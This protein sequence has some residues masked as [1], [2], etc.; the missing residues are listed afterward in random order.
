MT[1]SQVQR[2]DFRQFLLSLFA[3]LA[4]DQNFRCCFK[5]NHRELH[6][7]FW[8]LKQDDPGKDFVEDLLFDR[9]GNYAHCDEVDELL[10]EFQLSGVLARP[11]PTYKF[12]DIA[13]SSGSYAEDFRKG[14]T[15]EQLEKYHAVLTRFKEELGVRAPRR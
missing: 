3:D 15:P 1:A 8:S 9:N 6:E 4:R 13:L 14:L 2:L 5:A 10:Q 12:N 7:F 11:N